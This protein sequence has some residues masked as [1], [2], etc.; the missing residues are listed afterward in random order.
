MS[1]LRGVEKSGAAWPVSLLAK[2]R[3]TAYLVIH[4][5]YSEGIASVT[6]GNM[7]V[8]LQ[9]LSYSIYLRCCRV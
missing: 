6:S 1:F 5:D 4:S 8:F 9:Y 7:I 2:K 3:F